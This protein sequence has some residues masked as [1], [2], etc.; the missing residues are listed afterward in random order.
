MNDTNTELYSPPLPRVIFRNKGLIDIRGVTTFGVCAKDP[1][2]PH[3]TGFFGTGLKYAIAIC[4]RE[5][6]DIELRRGNDRHVF[7]LVEEEIRG[8]QFHMVYMDGKP[9]AFTTELG[10]TWDLWQAYRELHYNAFDEP[11]PKVFS[12]DGDAELLNLG[13][14]TQFMVHGEAFKE[15]Y[16]ARN[17]IILNTKP[18]YTLPG[19]EIHDIGGGGGWM[20]YKGVRVRKLGKPALF[21][22][23]LTHDIRLT[24]NRTMQDN[25]VADITIARAIIQC[26]HVSLIQ[27]V[28]EASS[29]HFEAT[30]DYDWDHIM[31][32]ETFNKIMVEYIRT[33]FSGIN[34]SARTMYKK[35]EPEDALLEEVPFEKLSEVVQDSMRKAV[36]FWV[37]LRVPIHK[38][39]IRVTSVLSKGLSTYRH[40]KIYL[41]EDCTMQGV[42]VIASHIF[43]QYIYLLSK[44]QT[45]VT[46]IGHVVEKVIT[47]GER[48]LKVPL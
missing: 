7:H 4:L 48:L 45:N 8:K 38:Y 23:N 30:I 46:P 15:L 11:S 32:K 3:P 14:H 44:S 41:S 37:Y 42:R 36:A 24:E 39:P 1:S 27:Q 21:N 5:G 35:H 40:G 26:D 31:P 33:G 18:L 13:A 28:L 25:Y 6:L 22:Y 12:L 43:R 10:K 47:F 17:T 9:L 20:Y 2:N 34:T 16:D 19:V 29:R